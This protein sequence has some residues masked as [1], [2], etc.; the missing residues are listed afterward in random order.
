MRAL[1]A[2]VAGLHGAVGLAAP[3]DDGGPCSRDALFTSL[4]RDGRSFCSSVVEERCH[5][6]ATPT[7]Y[8]TYDPTVISTCTSARWGEGALRPEGS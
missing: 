8:A 1:A 3:H 5:R 6:E 7:Q 2:L 4:S